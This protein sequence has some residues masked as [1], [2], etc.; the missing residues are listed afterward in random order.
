MSL[1]QRVLATMKSEDTEGAFELY[2]TRTPGYLWAL[3]FRSLHVHPIAV[4]L[5]SIVIGA[6]AG[7]FFYFQ[8]L[9]MT[10]SEWDCL[11]GPTGTTAPTGN[12]HA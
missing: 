9:R 2:V 1:K 12:W 11:S 6:S 7:Y 8:D 10:S 4:T 5:L 3:L